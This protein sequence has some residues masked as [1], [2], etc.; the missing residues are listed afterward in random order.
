[1][2][3]PSTDDSIKLK[4]PER[5]RNQAKLIVKTIVQKLKNH[6]SYVEP[7]TSGVKIPFENAIYN[8]IPDQDVWS[9]TVIDRLMKYLS[10][11]TKV[12][13]DSRPRIVD[14]TTNKYYPVST[15]EDLKEALI[16]MERGGSNIRPYIADFYR[17]VF[18]PKYVEV[19]SELDGK[20]RSDEIHKESHVG[21]TSEEI[22]E[23]LRQF[24]ITARYKLRQFPI[25]ASY[26]PD[27][28]AISRIS[29][30]PGNNAVCISPILSIKCS[31]NGNPI[32]KIGFS[33][34]RSI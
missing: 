5:D 3:F 11:I 19:Y 6:S 34:Y 15:F 7:K 1:M 25:T 18:K 29:L 22:A 28:T 21:I 23:K 10:I 13:M 16:L 12:N 8:A 32:G 30:V 9:M 31:I 20:A 33:I 4:G 26:K 14:T 17:K 27:F 24:P 2:G